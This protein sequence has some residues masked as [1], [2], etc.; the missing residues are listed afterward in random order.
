MEILPDSATSNHPDLSLQTISL[1]S[2]STS[3]KPP[4]PSGVIPTSSNIS[5]R[6]VNTERRSSPMSDNHSGWVSADFLSTL[7]TPP[8]GKDHR[9]GN[10]G[11]CE[12]RWPIRISCPYSPTLLSITEADWIWGLASK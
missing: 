3:A 8:P 6:S 7:L 2:S 10:A 11:S 4:F 12:L 9:S 5:L 1:T